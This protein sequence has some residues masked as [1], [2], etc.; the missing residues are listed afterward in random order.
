MIISDV[1]FSNDDI[2]TLLDSMQMIIINVTTSAKCQI[3]ESKLCRKGNSVITQFFVCFVNDS[4]SQ[5]SLHDN[6]VLMEL[7]ALGSLQSDVK[8]IA[9]TWKHISKLAISYHSVY[10]T[11]QQQQMPHHPIEPD[12]DSL[13]W[14]NICIESICKL[15]DEN[16]QKSSDAVKIIEFRFLN[17]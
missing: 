4:N 6:T 13:D 12:D 9:S 15:I 11:L 3:D 2:K 16:L 17:F 10:R 1:F 5:F 14:L 7:I 8:S